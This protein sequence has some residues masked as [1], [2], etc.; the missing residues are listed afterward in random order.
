MSLDTQSAISYQPE[1][2]TT[3]KVLTPE[4]MTAA[5][6]ALRDCCD[7]LF[8]ICQDMYH[9]T[10]ARIASCFESMKKLNQLLP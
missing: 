10:D 5:I 3:D 7:H 6:V 2:K 1:G 9:P 4:Q 8:S